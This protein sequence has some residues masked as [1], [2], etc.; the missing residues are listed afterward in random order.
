MTRAAHDWMSP[1][2][3]ACPRCG[4]GAS[5]DCIKLTEPRKGEPM[6]T[7]HRARCGLQLVVNPSAREATR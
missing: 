6:M 4:V 1:I 7:Y 3:Y 5:E 2:N